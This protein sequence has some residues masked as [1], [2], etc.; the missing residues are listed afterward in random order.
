[1]RKTLKNAQAIAFTRTGKCVQ[2]DTTIFVESAVV[3]QKRKWYNLTKIYEKYTYYMILGDSNK[4]KLKHWSYILTA[5]WK[6]YRNCYRK[7]SGISKRGIRGDDDMKP[8]ELKKMT[9]YELIEIIYELEKQNQSLQQELDAANQKLQERTIM[10]EES[11]SIADAALRLNHVFE[12]VQGAVTDYVNNMKRITL[13]KC[14][15]IIRETELEAKGITD[16][17]QETNHHSK[18]GGSGEGAHPPV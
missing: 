4:G 11:G 12:S 9:R 10:V 7:F 15:K 1:M 5:D 13:E 8:K 14:E 2:K 16:G 3:I 18:L 17:Q 6:R